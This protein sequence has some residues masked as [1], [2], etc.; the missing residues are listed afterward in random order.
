MGTPDSDTAPDSDDGRESCLAMLNHIDNYERYDGLCKNYQQG[1][2]PRYCRENSNLVSDF[3]CRFFPLEYDFCNPTHQPSISPT[4]GPTTEIKTTV[5]ESNQ[6]D[7]V[8][9]VSEITDIVEDKVLEENKSSSASKLSPVVFFILV[10][11]IIL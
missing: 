3:C 11:T 2:V 6:S 7:L 5:E 10:L 1:Y 9:I 4:S 8:E